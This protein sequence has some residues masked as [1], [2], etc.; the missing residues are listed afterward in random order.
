MFHH[1]TQKLRDRGA[2]D[3]GKLYF[4]YN[5]KEAG[6]RHERVIPTLRLPSVQCAVA[7]KN[8]CITDFPLPRLSLCCACPASNV[9]RALIG[10]RGGQSHVLRRSP[11]GAVV[12]MMESVA[13]EPTYIMEKDQLVPLMVAHNIIDSVSKTSSIPKRHSVSDLGDD[14]VDQLYFDDRPRI[15]DNGDLPYVKEGLFNA[16]AMFFLIL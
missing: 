6:K 10:A 2:E 16:R 1:N 7:H 14:E 13:F 15:M 11:K 9:Q 5:Q 4:Y 12:V 3:T 8:T